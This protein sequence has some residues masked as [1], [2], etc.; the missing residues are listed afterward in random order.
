MKIKNYAAE[1]SKI[2]KC[3]TLKAC[4]KLEE[5]F[6]RCHDEDFFTTSDYLTLDGLLNEK[7]NE[8]EEQQ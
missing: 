7:R 3:K 6:E 5:Y 4:D 8:I 1:V 2:E